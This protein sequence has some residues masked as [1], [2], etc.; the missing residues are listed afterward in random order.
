[1]VFPLAI[2][3]IVFSLSVGFVGLAVR[4]LPR[5]RAGGNEFQIFWSQPGKG[6]WIK[7]AVVIVIHIYS[8]PDILA[9]GLASIIAVKAHGRIDNA[10]YG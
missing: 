9:V 7:T 6:V 10:I 1:M 3:G 5:Y 4:I 2:K 8:C